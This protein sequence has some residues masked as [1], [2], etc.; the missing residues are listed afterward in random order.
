MP[1][2]PGPISDTAIRD[3]AALV[4]PG[5]SSFLLTSETVGAA[6]IDHL[7][8]TQTNTVQLVDSVGV[9]VYQ[10][11]RK[12]LPVVRIVQVIHVVDERAIE[13]AQHSA[14]HADALLLDSGNPKAVVKTLGGTGRVHDW[15]ISRRIVETVNIPVFLAGGLR[16][17]NVRQAI[18]EVQ[19]YGVDVCSGLRTGGKLDP[20]KVADFVMAV[21]G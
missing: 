11:I 15:Q 8:R 20:N 21:R 3:L 18:D 1:N 9:D 14:R 16:P 10:Q 17:E 2:G 4:P 13:E 12:V 19:P 6:I 7:S 5:V